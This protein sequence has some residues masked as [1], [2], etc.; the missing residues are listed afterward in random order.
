MAKSKSES[1]N[2]AQ[3]GYAYWEK[4][5]HILSSMR[6]KDL[7]QAAVVRGLSFRNTV[8][9]SVMELQGWLLKNWENI[10][11]KTLLNDYDVWLEKELKDEGLE[12]LIHPML[13]LGYSGEDDQ[14]NE[15]KRQIKNIAISGGVPTKKEIALFKPK[16]GSKKSYVYTLIRK[17][18]RIT[19]EELIE[20][21]SEQF[22]DVS[23]GS[24]KSWA[25]RARKSN[26]YAEELKLN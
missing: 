19:T 24:I 3:Y 13:R 5:N 6:I 16:K 17:N 15:V 10:L 11:D 2:Q 26:K 14:G 22:P 1:D 21:V 25:S 8:E 4:I 9:F 12:Y 18:P 23:I 20:T 7:K